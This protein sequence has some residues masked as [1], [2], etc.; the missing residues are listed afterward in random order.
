MVRL[1]FP[2]FKAIAFFILF[3]DDSNSQYHWLT[4]T[5]TQWPIQLLMYSVI[6]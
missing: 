1:H 5:L 3:Y 2:F 4:D 6:T